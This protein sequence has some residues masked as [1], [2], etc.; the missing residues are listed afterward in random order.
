M[1]LLRTE[2]Y[3]EDRKVAS[4]L[5]HDPPLLRTRLVSSVNTA[6]ACQVAGTG[7]G[8]GTRL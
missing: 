5:Q 2:T 8:A 7:N 4:C 6:S 3:E 1:T